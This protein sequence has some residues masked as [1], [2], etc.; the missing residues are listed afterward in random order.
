MRG[1]GGRWVPTARSRRAVQS[2]LSLLCAELRAEPQPKKKRSKLEQQYG[3]M[4]G[5]AVSA[6]RCGAGLCGARGCRPS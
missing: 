4:A 6:P 5:A 3:A 2:S 1:E